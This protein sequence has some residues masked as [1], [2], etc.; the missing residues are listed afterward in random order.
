MI[1]S[2]DE[3]IIKLKEEIENLKTENKNLQEENNLIKVNF[4]F[5]VIIEKLEKSVKSNLQDID[6]TV[7]NYKNNLNSISDQVKHSKEA[8]T[9]NNEKNELNKLQ[10]IIKDDFD[11]VILILTQD[12]NSKVQLIN[13][14]FQQF[15]EGI[16]YS[17]DKNEN[18]NISFV[19]KSKSVKNLIL[20]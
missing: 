9:V 11:L 13:E 7:D 12:F 10:E 6:N 15:F 4:N 3:E 18:K 2:K 20:K 14:Q 8:K 16:A 5:D 1:K 19:N 17:E